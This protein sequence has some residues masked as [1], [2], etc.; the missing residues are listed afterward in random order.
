MVGW[1]V[2]RSDGHTQTRS[3]ATQKDQRHSVAAVVACALLYPS[4]VPNYPRTFRYFE[5]GGRTHKHTHAHNR[6]N[7]ESRGAE[8]DLGCCV[9]ASAPCVSDG[10]DDDDD[11]ERGVIGNKRRLC[12][13]RL[14]VVV[15]Q[16]H[17]VHPYPHTCTHAR[18]DE[19]SRT[20][21]HTDARTRWQ[22]PSPPIYSAANFLYSWL[23][24]FC[25]ARLRPPLQHGTLPSR[26]FATTREHNCPES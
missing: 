15:R 14:V 8:R 4:F 21:A 1:L 19:Y 2:G 26:E 24:C 12:W 11:E 23:N 13:R 9:P 7:C 10:E 3:G 6:N 17:R 16:T 18:T 22:S 20:D 5:L 25:P